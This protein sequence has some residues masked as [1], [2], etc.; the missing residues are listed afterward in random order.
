MMRVPQT[1]HDLW[2]LQVPFALRP[3]QGLLSYSTG[4]IARGR[5]GEVENTYDVTGTGLIIDAR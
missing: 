2:K 1:A 4:R 5:T 3:R